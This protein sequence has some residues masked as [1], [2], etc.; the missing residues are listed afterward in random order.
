MLSATDRGY[1]VEHRRFRDEQLA[2]RV[3]C[4]CCD[5]RPSSEIHHLKPLRG[6]RYDQDKLDPNN[7]LCV[8]KPCHVFISQQLEP[9]MPHGVWTKLVVFGRPGAGKSTWALAHAMHLI[10]PVDIWDWD[11][12]RPECDSDDHCTWMRQRWAVEASGSTYPAIMICNRC[13]DAYQLAQMMVARLVYIPC[14]EDTRQ[15]R[16]RCRLSAPPSH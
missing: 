15:E 1:G 12:K 7:V 8:C 14:D 13:S 11:V 3:V 10:I 4:E 9:N 2:W 5:H 6:D 16:L